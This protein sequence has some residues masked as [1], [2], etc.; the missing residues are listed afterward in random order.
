MISNEPIS[1]AL[2]RTE[3]DSGLLESTLRGLGFAAPTKKIHDMK[4]AGIIIGVK[5]GLYVL[6]PPYAREPVV[7]ETLANLIYGPSYISL[8]DAL[9]YLGLIPERVETVT[10]VTSSR[11]KEFQTPLGRFT[12]RYLNPTKYA[13]EI[14]LVWIDK[15]HPVLMATAEKA[16][17]DYVVLNKIR[18]LAT[19]KDARIF[20]EEDLR[21][22]GHSWTRL[23]PLDLHRINRVYKSASLDSIARLLEGAHT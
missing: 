12:Y 10:S 5:K 17:A 2:R 23:Q 18:N 3:F 6:S 16:L 7:K 9:S 14:N 21:I 1:H 22:D 19:P 8:E 15:Q 13:L 11:D 20:L 4:K